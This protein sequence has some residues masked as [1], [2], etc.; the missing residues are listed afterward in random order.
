MV[1]IIFMLNPKIFFVA[2]DFSGQICNMSCTSIVGTTHTWQITYCVVLYLQCIYTY[3]CI[4]I[5]VYIHI[6]TYMYIYCM[7]VFSKETCVLYTY[8]I[9]NLS[10]RHHEYRINKSKNENP[11]EEL[12]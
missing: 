7:F 6:Y 8:N 9:I 2:S 12:R 4:Y 3:M 1:N 5:L 11:N 10:K